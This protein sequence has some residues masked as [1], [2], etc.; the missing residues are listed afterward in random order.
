MF[1]NL[2]C[3][4]KTRGVLVQD[5]IFSALKHHLGCMDVAEKITTSAVE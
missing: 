3:A 2:H 5:I 1:G 4:L